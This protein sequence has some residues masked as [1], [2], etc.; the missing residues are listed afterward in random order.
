MG[1]LPVAAALVVGFAVHNT[2]EGVAVIAPLT[3][4]R[5]ST[6]RLLGLRLVA[7][8]PAVLGTVLGATVTT[9]RPGGLPPRAGVGAILRV[10][11]PIAPLLRGATGRV[12]DGPVIGGLAGGVVVM[13]LSGLLVTRAA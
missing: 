3:R 10:V 5:V 12:L 7:L 6:G 9:P 11:V 1:Q 13:Y 8:A 2:T 4:Q